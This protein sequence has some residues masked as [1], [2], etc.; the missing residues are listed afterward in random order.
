MKNFE[1]IIGIIESLINIIL[2]TKK[3]YPKEY[4]ENISYNGTNLRVPKFR[5]KNKI[6]SEFIKTTL[7]NTHDFFEKKIINAI[8]L[9]IVKNKEYEICEMYV[10]NIKRVSAS[11]DFKLNEKLNNT[12]MN[13]IMLITELKNFIEIMESESTLLSNDELTFNIFA[14]VVPR[15]NDLKLLTNDEICNNIKNNNFKISFGRSAWP[16]Q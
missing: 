5:D 1:T 3:I 6:Y 9:V 10:F 11:D 7:L 13:E 14:S 16:W 4:F 15:I 2:Y 8:N 12:K